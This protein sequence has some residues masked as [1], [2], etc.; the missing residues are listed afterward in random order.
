MQIATLVLV[1][2]E[3]P[4]AAVLLGYKKTGFGQ[5]K[6]TGFGGKVE[7]GETILSAA[8]RELAE[9]TGLQVPHEHLNP[10]AILAFRF[11][12]KPGWSQ[13]VHV[14]TTNYNGQEPVES[15]EIVPQWFPYEKIPYNSMWADVRHWLPRILGGER[16][17]ATFHFNADN[18][19]LSWF[20]FHPF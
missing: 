13:E 2:K 4:K 19:T 17:Q 11:P 16:F 15:D 6:F 12:Y 9:E 1:L 3:R 7:I 20:E 14:F 18:N 8:A 10:A 5:G